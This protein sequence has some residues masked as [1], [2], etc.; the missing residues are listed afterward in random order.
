MGE[1]WPKPH[2]AWRETG[3]AREG[4]SEHLLLWLEETRCRLGGTCLLR[5]KCSHRQAGA[6]SHKGAPGSQIFS[7]SPTHCYR[8]TP[9]F[10]SSLLCSSVCSF[11]GSSLAVCL[12]VCLAVFLTVSLAV[13]GSVSVCLS[14]PGSVFS[15]VDTS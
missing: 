5:G 6:L 8:L 9:T 7:N 13:S 15:G 12:A 3:C 2:G 10:V 11:S 1:E 4:R 14:V